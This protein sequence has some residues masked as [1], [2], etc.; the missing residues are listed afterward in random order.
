MEPNAYLEI[1]RQSW[2]KRTDV[3]VTS[4]FYDVP[5]F[6]SGKS[7]LNDIELNLLGDV[8]GK[9]VLHLQCHFG[10]DSISLSRLGAHV[11]GV[12]LS[13]NAIE[14]ANELAGKAGTS[15]TFIC[16]DLYDLPNHLQDQF[17]IVFTSYGTIGWLPDIEKWA[18]VISKFMKPG[19]S[20]VFAE[21][22]PVA[23]MFDNDF[24]TVA[25]RYFNDEP[26]VENEVNTYADRSNTL[27]LKSV[28]WNHGLAEVIDALIKQGITITH[29][30]EFDYSPYDC[31]NGA[32]ENEPGKFRIEKF[33][34]KL[35]LVYAVKGIK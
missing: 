10:M 4:A 29:F 1:N 7:S 6:L 24:N 23:W 11:T 17:D 22:H 27:E 2:N 15:T 5:T 31:F 9:S 12:D 32:I 3:H 14:K 33:G 20:F 28:C 18:S 35:P 25:Y 21:F 34:N 8:A 19:G 16:S 30:Q 26:I 13:D